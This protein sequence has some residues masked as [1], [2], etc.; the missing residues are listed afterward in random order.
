MCEVG[1]YDSDD[2]Y[3]LKNSVYLN[4]ENTVFTGPVDVCV[5]RLLH[6]DYS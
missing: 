4:N 5:T 2:D 6:R 3:M 1:G